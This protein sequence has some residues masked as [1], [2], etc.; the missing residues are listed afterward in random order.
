M[1]EAQLY[2]NIAIWS[3]V[4]SS[5]VFIGVLVFVWYRWL[6]PLLMAAQDRSNRQI[7][8][9]ERHRDEAKAALQTLRED[10]EGA[11]HD[12]K[13]IEQ[14]VN[15]RSD[16]ERQALLQE[17]AEAG[18]RALA[19]A[20]RELERARAAARQRRYAIAIAALARE[21]DAVERVSADLQA[22]LGVIGASKRI[23]EFFES[24]VIDRPAKERALAEVFEGKVHP[25]AL[26]ALL[27]LVRKRRET[28]LS[29]I[30]S[31][32]LALEREARGIEKLKLETARELDPA[33]YDRLVAQLERL[34][35]KK[36]EVTHVVDRSLIGGLRIMMGDRRIDASISGR[37]DSLARE[38]SHIS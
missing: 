14:R 20:G 4:L 17:T 3:Q 30:V 6:L 18:E 24:P 1:N 21:Q 12:A 37:L 22:I 32:Y 8:E 25:I 36:F 16:H 28:F 23:R 19:E 7:A 13:L 10:I 33:E 31:E 34:Y 15:D 38:L 26:H 35:S 2:L 9:A 29:A 27:L 11:H 5:I